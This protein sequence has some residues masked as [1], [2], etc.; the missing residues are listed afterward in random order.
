MER[1]FFDI[2]TKSSK[3]VLKGSIGAPMPEKPQMRFRPD[4]GKGSVVGERDRAKSAL[5]P[6]LEE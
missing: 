2:T 5:G 3:R 4:T 6:G 1:V